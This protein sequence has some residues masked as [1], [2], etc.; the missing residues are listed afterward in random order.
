MSKG[1]TERR[2]T[3]HA[4]A[5][6]CVFSMWKRPLDSLTFLGINSSLRGAA[7]ALGAGPLGDLGHNGFCQAVGGDE[8]DAP[9]VHGSQASLARGVDRRH[10]GQV[11]AKNWFSLAGQGGLPAIL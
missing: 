9:S 11:H 10:P 1:A 6:E 2:K 4:V 7:V 3:V 5:L 8:L